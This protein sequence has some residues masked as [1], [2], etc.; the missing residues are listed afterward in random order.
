VRADRLVATLLVL[1]ARG[2]VTAAEVAAELEVSVRTARRDLE[3]L[4]VAGIPVYSQSGRNGGWSLVGGART[5]LSGL[6]AA[7]ARTLFLIAGP[8]SSV[9]PEA[10]AALRK[11]V[12]ALP[13]S[14]RADAEAA[15][16]AIVLDPTGWG[17]STTP[18][19]EFLDVLQQAVVDG[20]QVELGYA[21]RERTRTTRVVHPLGLVAKGPVWYLL[22][23]TAA[24]R[25]TFRVSRVRSVVVTDEPAE[26]PQGFDLAEAWQ[27]VVADVDE[28]RTTF[29]ATALVD[30]SV[31]GILVG[32]LG[33]RLT[34]G[35]AG[36]DGRIEVEVG[37]F[38]PEEVAYDLACYP[39]AV[40]VLGP[41]EVRALLAT[42]G[43]Q[44]VERYATDEIAAAPTS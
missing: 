10:K 26:R 4:A 11:L 37:G 32:H 3:A 28:R 24:G 30:P 44:L 22:A 27:Q 5:D 16:S 33:T 39:G 20:L 2:R 35:D 34:V 14:F 41:P 6:T 29:R 36:P 25:R 15:A 21:D 31:V 43:R 1:Q 18:R 38:A 8:S 40:E 23:D 9:T 42:I 7:E 17:S 19:P 12:Q 13:E